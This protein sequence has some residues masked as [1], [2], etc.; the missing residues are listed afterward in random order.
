MYPRIWTPVGTRLL[1]NEVMQSQGNACVDYVLDAAARGRDWLTDL[2][3]TELVI[4]SQVR[5]R[6]T[7]C[8]LRRTDGSESAMCMQT[9]LFVCSLCGRVCL[10]W[11]VCG[12]VLL[13]ALSPLCSI[14]QSWNPQTTREY[15][16]I[17]WKDKFCSVPTMYSPGVFEAFGVYAQQHGNFAD[18]RWSIRLSS[19]SRKVAHPTPIDDNPCGSIDPYV[20]P[21][22]PSP[23]PPPFR[24]RSCP[25]SRYSLIP[26]AG[27]CSP[28][29]SPGDD[30]RT[31]MCQIPALAACLVLRVFGGRNG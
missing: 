31:I 2:A 15:S 29:S 13:L 30:G 20:A 5:F 3:G 25:P 27:P 17:A 18:S 1:T 12:G 6:Q 22:P 9:P 28:P 4:F 24:C 14:T 7:I 21:S 26:S 10:V 16:R 8:G 19:N 23:L 11:S